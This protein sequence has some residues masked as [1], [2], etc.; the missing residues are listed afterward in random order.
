MPPQDCFP[1][2]NFQQQT[3]IDSQKTLLKQDP[4]FL[5]A[6]GPRNT[7]VIIWG[8]SYKYSNYINCCQL[9]CL[10]HI[11]KFLAPL[12]AFIYSRECLFCRVGLLVLFGDFIFSRKQ[13]DGSTLPDGAG[14]GFGG[15]PTAT[16]TERG[17]Q[18]WLTLDPHRQ[19]PAIR[20]TTSQYHRIKLLWTERLCQPTDKPVF[21][22]L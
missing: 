14:R 15:R 7:K 22:E 1:G 13:P 3:Q 10:P 21:A 9:F 16:G 11:G 17:D 20:R 8:G 5:S 6:A 4:P 12:F 19:C 18:G 2:E